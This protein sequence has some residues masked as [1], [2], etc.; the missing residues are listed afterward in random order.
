[1]E[2]GHIAIGAE[3]VFLHIV[4]QT[5][6]FHPAGSLP[7]M[8]VGV[9]D[10][11]EALHRLR[12]RAAGLFPDQGRQTG[13]VG[14]HGD[15]GHIQHAIDAG[16]GFVNAPH[17]CTGQRNS[18]NAGHHIAAAAAAGIDRVNT[19]ALIQRFDGHV[20][21]GHLK[22]C[23][24]IIAQIQLFAIVTHGAPAEELCAL[25]A[26]REV[27]RHGHEGV[28]RHNG[29]SI[30][31]LLPGTEVS[32]CLRI[33]SVDDVAVGICQIAVFHAVGIALIADDVARIHAEEFQ[34]VLIAEILVFQRDMTAE[35]WIVGQDRCRTGKGLFDVD[36]L[37]LTQMDIALGVVLKGRVL[38]GHFGTA[39][40]RQT[41]A[42]FSA[43]DGAA[44][45]LCIAEIAVAVNDRAFRIRG[46]HR[47]AV[48]AQ[49]T[50]VFDG[51][52]GIRGN[53]AVVDLHPAPVVLDAADTHRLKNAVCCGAIIDC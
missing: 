38:Q 36:R 25:C 34:L 14:G 40:V 8:K 10:V 29:G 35:A 20:A 43:L 4:H 41:D 46:S 27:C 7:Q 13:A 39:K 51:A 50:A 33:Y 52:V 12:F 44:V 11:A 53:G 5:L 17:G 48:H 42:V 30:Q 45:D 21:A 47:A 6:L 37:T 16:S 9:I 49:A 32:G 31:L 26:L 18:R 28:F 22:L 24:L 15:A 19:A 3:L 2:L 23:S 1:M